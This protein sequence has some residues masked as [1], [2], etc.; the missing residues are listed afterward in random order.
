MDRG[1]MRMKFI[2]SFDTHADQ[3]VREI[4]RSEFGDVKVFTTSS[5]GI[6]AACGKKGQICSSKLVR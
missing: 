3:Q 6:A 5:I 4:F 2:A 1:Y